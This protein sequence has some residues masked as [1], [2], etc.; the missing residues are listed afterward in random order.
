MECLNC[1]RRATR[2][3]E[4]DRGGAGPVV[5]GARRSS[6]DPGNNASVY[7][8]G[9]RVLLRIR[10]GRTSRV[11]IPLSSCRVVGGNRACPTAS[12]RLRIKVSY[13]YYERRYVTR[14]SGEKLLPQTAI[15]RGLVEKNTALNTVT[16]RV[17][18]C[19]FGET[20]AT[21]DAP[22]GDG[23]RVRCSEVEKSSVFCTRRLLY[24]DYTRCGGGRF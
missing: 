2:V 23:N 21:P 13:Y 16:H 8:Y 18:T 20:F 4:Y 7:E 9:P 5:V 24:D 11:I 17:Y 15:C 10:C 6:S 1:R 12:Y 22:G 3:Y 14:V 19:V